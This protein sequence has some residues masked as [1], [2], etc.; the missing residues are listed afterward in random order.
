MVDEEDGSFDKIKVWI[1]AS[2]SHP[3]LFDTFEIYQL[4]QIHGNGEGI[5]LY[6]DDG[7]SFKEDQFL[8]V[9][10]IFQIPR[11]KRGSE[12]IY[13]PCF[14]ASSTGELLMDQNLGNS[15]RFG[16]FVGQ[17]GQD[18]TIRVSPTN[19]A[20]P[21]FTLDFTLFFNLIQ[22]FSLPLYHSL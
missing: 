19:L 9:N 15:V 20:L 4:R 22:Y 8:R 18:I 7:N 21:S 17:M 6:Q 10:V 3:I 13:L 14:K 1:E 11:V 5:G 2:Y 12:P 16:S